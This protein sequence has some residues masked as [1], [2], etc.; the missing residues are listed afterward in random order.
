M[1]NG[2]VGNGP[3][4]FLGAIVNTA[5][6]EVNW[7]LMIL[8]MACMYSLYIVVMYLRNTQTQMPI[9]CFVS[10]K[11]KYALL[12]NEYAQQTNVEI[13][14]NCVAVWNACSKLWV[15]Y[16]LSFKMICL[17]K[18]PIQSQNYTNWSVSQAAWLYHSPVQIQPLVFYENCLRNESNWWKISLETFAFELHQLWFYSHQSQNIWGMFGCC[19]C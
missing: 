11:R 12:K 7:L 17:N 6:N 15:A 1:Q 9:S 13:H 14:G 18:L 19:L 2:L 10:N 3:L 4:H 5:A 16:K 8:H